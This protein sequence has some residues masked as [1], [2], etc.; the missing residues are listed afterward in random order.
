MDLNKANCMTVNED[1][2][3]GE[4]SEKAIKSDNTA[5]H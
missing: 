5:N 2:L 3:I 1:D 4:K